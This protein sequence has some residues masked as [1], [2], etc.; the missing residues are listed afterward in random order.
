MVIKILC[1]LSGGVILSVAAVMVQRAVGD[2]LTCILLTTASCARARRSRFKTFKEKFQMNLVYVD[3]RERFLSKLAGVADPE[4]K[5]KIIGEEFIRVFEDEASKLGQID[6]LVQGTLYPDVVESGTATAAV[7][8][9][10]HNVGC[11]PEDMRFQLI[12]P[13][14]AGCLRMK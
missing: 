9:S 5:R 8:K 10:H 7:I 13:C 11:L 14:C 3:A 2:Q 4:K 6:Y 1:A 12:E